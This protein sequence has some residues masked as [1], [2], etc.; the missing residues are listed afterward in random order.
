MS[1]NF[2]CTLT[3][4]YENKRMTLFEQTRFRFYYVDYIL[5]KIHSIVSKIFISFTFDC[6]LQGDEWNSSV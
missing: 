4:Y 1:V 6:N 2:F 3:V 5:L